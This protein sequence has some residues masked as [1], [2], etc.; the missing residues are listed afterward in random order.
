[1]ALGESLGGQGVRQ[2]QEER[3]EAAVVIELHVRHVRSPASPVRQRQGEAGPLP[4]P[5]LGNHGAA[6]ALCDVLADRQSQAQAVGLGRHRIVVK[7]AVEQ[8]GDL[9]LLD[10]AA[11]VG[12]G[13][14]DPSVD[15]FQLHGHRASGRGKLQGIGEQLVEQQLDGGLVKSAGVAV[16]SAPE[17]QLD[18]FERKQT[19]SPGTDRTDRLR[20]IPVPDGEGRVLPQLSRRRQIVHQPQQAVVALIQQG[21]CGI[22]RRIPLPPDGRRQLGGRQVQ[23]SQH[24]AQLGG[25]VGEHNGEVKLLCFHRRILSAGILSCSI[26][27]EGLSNRGKACLEHQ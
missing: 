18:L 21:S 3:I 19:L 27:G 22:Q 5:G 6:V 11:G 2:G 14:A 4:R 17:F 9:V 13:Q 26:Y 24:A 23:V 20:Q 8:E 12:H 25:D 7:V 16:R 15:E 10:T 1:M